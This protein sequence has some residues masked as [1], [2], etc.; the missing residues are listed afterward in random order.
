MDN[1]RWKYRFDSISPDWDCGI[2]SHSILRALENAKGPE[3]NVFPRYE[4]YTPSFT[5]DVSV[6]LHRFA[7]DCAHRTLN[8]GETEDKEQLLRALSMKWTWTTSPYGGTG[9]MEKWIEEKMEELGAEA[10]QLICYDEKKNPN[11][12]TKAQYLKMYVVKYALFLNPLIAALQTATLMREVIR[13][14][15]QK[16]EDLSREHVWQEYHLLKL[17]KEKYN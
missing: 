16:N 14:E 3:L 4:D 17:C 11:V 5:V 10:C 6:Q 8:Y 9:Y 2:M 15:F 12:I 13:E 1:V 7:M